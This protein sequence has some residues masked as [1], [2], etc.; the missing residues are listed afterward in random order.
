ML[1]LAFS[2]QGLQMNM[3]RIAW[4]PRLNG[5]LSLHKFL[6]ITRVLVANNAKHFYLHFLYIHW[7]W[8]SCRYMASKLVKI[9][10]Q[11]RCF[12]GLFLSYHG[13]SI[14]INNFQHSSVAYELLCISR[15]TYVS[16][17]LYFN[18]IEKDQ[19]SIVH[20]HPGHKNTSNFT[21]PPL[22]HSY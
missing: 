4:I 19:N 13:Q 7:C 10:D 1:I 2:S 18:L 9:L 11:R 14:I 5:D 16:F 17:F 22:S 15:E 3:L 6:W 20:P 12:G 21:P 8:G